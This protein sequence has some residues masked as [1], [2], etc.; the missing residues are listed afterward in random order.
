MA[1]P[2]LCV[3]SDE[4]H[5]CVTVDEKGY[6]KRLTAVNWRE[7]MVIPA[8]RVVGY[9]PAPP[10]ETDKVVVLAKPPRDALRVA[11][12]EGGWELPMPTRSSLLYENL[13]VAF[14]LMTEP[15]NS[16][17]RTDIIEIEVDTSKTRI[18][19]AVEKLAEFYGDIE[20]V[21]LTR[22]LQKPIET[23]NYRVY[24]NGEKRGIVFEPRL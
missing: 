9:L 11:L 17:I 3:G 12:K 22:A 8:V 6:Y 13:V 20:L 7:A 14:T 4:F 2:T 19:S 23:E 5:S 1:A 18:E 15:G 21:D 24:W 16:I 10:D